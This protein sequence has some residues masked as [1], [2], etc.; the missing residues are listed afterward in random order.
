VLLPLKD[1]SV[2]FTLALQHFGKFDQIAGRVGEESELA[3]DGVQD[4]GLGDDHNAT[5]AK[6]GDRFIHACHVEAEMVVAA[7]FQAIA[8]LR[9]GTR[10][11]RKR[12]AAAQHLDV[13][14]IVRR[15]CQIS[16]LLVG[17]IPFRY[18]A[19]IALA[20]IEIRC[21]RQARRTNRDMV[22]R[23][24]RRRVRR[25]FSQAG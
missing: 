13:E 14:M 7:I 10:L 20:D 5:R 12:L 6:P 3:A 17:I 22:S 23:A 24:Y 8:K 9:I 11:R 16:E 15:R 2:G 21:F 25:Y 18:N 1:V 4:E 19:E